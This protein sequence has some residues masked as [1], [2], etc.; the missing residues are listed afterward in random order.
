[1]YDVVLFCV[2][3]GEAGEDTQSLRD[4]VGFSN[5]VLLCACVFVQER[6]AKAE[7]SGWG[8]LP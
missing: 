3:A 5:L 4:K 1:M 8:R 2:C 7:S 6:L